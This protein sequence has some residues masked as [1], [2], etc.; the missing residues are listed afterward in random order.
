[1]S[2]PAPT[3]GRPTPG[4]GRTGSPTGPTP[5][6]RSRSSRSSPAPRRRPAGARRRLRRGPG[7]PARPSA[8]GADGRRRRPDVAQIGVA[9][10]GGGARPTP[11]PARPACRSPTARSTRGGLPGVRAHRRRRR[12]HRRG[13]PGCSSPAAASCSS[14]TTR[15]CRR[16]AAAGSTTRSSTR[17]SST[18]ASARTWSRTRHRGGGEGRVH[19]VHP[20]S[21]VPLRERPGRATACS[22]RGWRSRRRRPGF[23]ARAAEYAEAADDPAAALP[24]HREAGS[25]DAAEPAA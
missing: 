17:R 7:G 18:G 15:C 22:S 13:R 5:S 25:V 10:P 4:G 23:L 21:A 9:E 6:T 16:P 3:S 19:P 24:A 2:D 8:G 14:S 11:G 20:P 1:M 12:G